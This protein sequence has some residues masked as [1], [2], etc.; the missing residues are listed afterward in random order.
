M[1]ISSIKIVRGGD[2]IEC[3]GFPFTHLVS[4]GQVSQSCF[5][6][7]QSVVGPYGHGRGIPRGTSECVVGVGTECPWWQLLHFEAEDTE[8]LVCGR[9]GFVGELSDQ[10]S[11]FA[12]AV[13]SDES[14]FPYGFV[15]G[16]LLS[17]C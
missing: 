10:H 6:V 17:P 5:A 4:M 3:G 9:L 14:S 15:E 1:F 12:I 13:V 7:L 16:D 11:C 8:W 2:S